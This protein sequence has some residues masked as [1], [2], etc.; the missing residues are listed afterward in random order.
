MIQIFGL[1]A[2]LFGIMALGYLAGRIAKLPLEGLAWANFFVIYIALP[3]MFFKLLSQTSLTEFAGYRFIAITTMATLIIFC[4]CFFIAC[5]RNY[6]KD[7]DANVSVATIQGFAG[8]YGNIGYM[9]PPM[10]LVAFGPAGIAPAALI[11]SFDNALHFILAPLLMSLNE[12]GEKG[13]ETRLIP[14]F[15]N[16]GWKIITHPFILATIAGFTAAALSYVPPEPVTT[17]L[18]LLAGAAAPC[19]LFI[20]GV[21]AALRP[22]KRVPDELF[23]LVPVKLLVHPLLAFWMVTSLGD[24]PPILVKTA[25]LMAALPSATNVFVL[26]EQ[27]GVW[28][29]RASSAV[30]VS[31]V[32]SVLTL[33]IVLYYLTMIY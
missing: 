22:L 10:V 2:P 11:F 20:M 7:G 14:V 26:A 13:E 28:Q 31:T 33:S 18:D 4:L 16:I 17:I 23:Y 30:I 3:A 19:A 1:I 6:Y 21:T 25:V 29:E 15:V 9:G 24:F 32:A 8:A 5:G 27:Y 12:Q